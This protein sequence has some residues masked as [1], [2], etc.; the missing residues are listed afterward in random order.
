M[1]KSLDEILE[2]VKYLPKNTIAVAQAADHDILSVANIA[3]EKGISN[4]IFVGNPDT[5]RKYISEGNYKLEKVPIVEA[6]DDKACAIMAVELVTSGKAQM[7]MKGLLSTAT[8]MRAVLDK[9]KGLRT[10][11]LISQITITDKIDGTGLNFITDC[12][13]NI[14]PTLEDKISIV[15]NAVYLARKFGYDCPKV[16]MLTALETVNPNMQETLDAAALSKMNDRGQIKNCIVDGP[17]ALDNAISRTSAEHKGVTGPVA[18]MADI[19]AVS[20]IRM[21]NVLHKAI[22]YFAQKR[23]G[24]V[25][26][27]TSSPLVMTSRSDS[28]EDKLISIA[29]SSYLSSQS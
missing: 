29:A 23:I 1:I 22:T 12:A 26:I 7:P 3:L 2:K 18:G 14:N 27:G 28:V 11:S 17:F 6:F 10:G 8:F 19:L 24:S 13:M 21:G 15:N 16:A 9:E 20:D 5:I 4:F 25:I